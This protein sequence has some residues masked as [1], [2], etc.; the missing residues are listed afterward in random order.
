MYVRETSV[1]TVRNNT[2]IYLW[3]FFYIIY[4]NLPVNYSKIIT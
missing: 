1:L 2:V 3:K 4:G